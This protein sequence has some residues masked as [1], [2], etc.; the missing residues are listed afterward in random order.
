MCYEGLSMD[1]LVTLEVALS[2]AVKMEKN[3][4]TKKDMKYELRRI[5]KAMGKGDICLQ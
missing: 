3:E 1:S 4:Q 2:R 5:L